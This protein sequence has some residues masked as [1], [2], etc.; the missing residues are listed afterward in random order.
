MNPKS[1][2]GDHIKSSFRSNQVLFHEGKKTTS[3]YC[4]NVV[5]ITMEKIHQM[6]VSLFG[7]CHWD[8]PPHWHGIFLPCQQICGLLCINISVFEI[9]YSNTCIFI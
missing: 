7:I 4:S 2:D 8:A 1:S 3:L 9:Y 6:T 5:I